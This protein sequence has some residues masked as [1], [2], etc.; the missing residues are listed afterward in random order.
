MLRVTD[1]KLALEG[2]PVAPLTRGEIVLDVDDPVL[3][4]NTRPLKVSARDGRLKTGTE[5]KGRPR[6]PR[7]SVPAEALGP[8]L[9]GALS[10]VAAAAAGLIESSGGAAEIAEPWFR[11]RPAFLHSLNVF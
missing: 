11:A 4:A 9:A 10:P 2:F 3:P 5:A 6:L 7:L 8:L 1:V